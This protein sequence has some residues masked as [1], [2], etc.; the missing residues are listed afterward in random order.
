MN[1][2]LRF[3]V[4]FEYK[5]KNLRKIIL[6]KLSKKGITRKIDEFGKIVIWFIEIYSVI[7]K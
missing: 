4:N 1:R 2:E 7:D 5:M 6:I 3:M